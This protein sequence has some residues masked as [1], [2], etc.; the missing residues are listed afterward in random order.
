MTALDHL[1]ALLGLGAI[2]NDTNW[3]A[4]CFYCE[5]ELWPG[6]EHEEDC[7]YVAAKKFVEAQ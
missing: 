3:G 6:A 5:K 1:R 2:Y 7:L 4:I